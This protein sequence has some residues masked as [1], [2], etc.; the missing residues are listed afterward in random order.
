MA[1]KRPGILQD[2]S[3]RYSIA[4][5]GEIYDWEKDMHRI[6][7]MEYA[8][9][10]G[11][12]EPSYILKLYAKKGFSGFSELNGSFSCAIHDALDEQLILVTDRLASWP[13]YY[14]VTEDGDL[15]FSTEI[16]GLLQ[17]GAFQAK[18]DMRALAELLGLQRV[19]GDKSLVEGVYWLRPG[20]ILRWTPGMVSFDTYWKPT[21]KAVSGSVEDYA[22]EMARAVKM[23]L[24]RRMRDGKKAG[25]LLSGGLDSRMILAGSQSTLECFTFGDYENREYQI[26]RRISAARGFTGIFLQ[27]EPGHYLRLLASAVRIGSGMYAFN[28]AHP[29]GFVDRIQ[30]DYGC[31]VLYHGFAPELLFRGTNIP[32]EVKQFNGIK[33]GRKVHFIDS[34]E[35]LE[36]K[37]LKRN[38]NLFPHRPWKVL[39]NVDEKMVFEFY[40]DTAK[41]LCTEAMAY[42]NHPM[43]AYWWPDV[44]YHS[45]YPSYLFQMSLRPF[46]I[47]R[48]IVFDNDMIDL[49][50][51][52]PTEMRCDNRVWIRAMKKLCPSIAR[53]PDA[54]TGSIPTLPEL[55]QYLY[56]S[57]KKVLD[58]LPFAWR[59]ASLK[60]RRN[61]QP[62]GLSPI[63][64][65]RFDWM[66]I[67]DA[68]LR[69]KIHD[70]ICD[71]RYI[72][73]EIFDVNEVRRIFHDHVN[74]IQSNRNI[75]FLLLTFSEW[76]HL[77]LNT[78]SC[79]KIQG[80]PY[81]L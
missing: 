59:L 19:Y 44:Y 50:L 9:E 60:N 25:M 15:V 26:A 31:D 16:Y 75:L 42:V 66:I 32:Y 57:R 71:P 78:N 28:H 76:Y 17:S 36:S 48:G 20:T 1:E 14:A 67:H 52:M 34:E 33:Y 24:D 3:G 12:S 81:G 13:V 41:M 18:L 29:I 2:P 38:Y 37:I 68:S 65:P 58:R 56:S 11:Y 35:E 49:H 53:I 6:W 77:M 46:L 70:V 55:L 5:A 79:S 40:R 22:E 73:P 43:D 45:R 47:E 72:D 30:R 80:D 74:G 69:R 7:D 39:R 61:P 23:A 27:R 62:A 54:N 64:W 8:G 21:Y 10:N 63:S 51:R 4:M